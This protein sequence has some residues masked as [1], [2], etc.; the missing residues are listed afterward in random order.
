MAIILVWM[1]APKASGDSVLGRHHPPVVPLSGTGIIGTTIR[2]TIWAVSCFAKARSFVKARQNISVRHQ[3][4]S[5]GRG[6][7]WVKL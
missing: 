6:S 2:S 1:M 4:S 5:M 3:I 7:Q